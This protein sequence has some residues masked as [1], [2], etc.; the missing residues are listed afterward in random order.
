MKPTNAEVSKIF[1]NVSSRY[2]A[3]TNPYAIRRRMEFFVA[4]AEGKCLE[5]G[6][7][8]GIISQALVKA[9]HDVTATDIAPKMAEIITKKGIKAVVCDAEKLPFPDASF[10][11]VLASEMLYYLDRPQEFLLEAER[12]LK[13]GGVLLISSANAR[14]AWL[15]DWL[16]AVLRPFGVG[17]TY[18]DDPVHTFIPQKDLCRL[19]EQAEFSA[20]AANK[21]LVLPVAF[22]DSFNR[23][24]ECT[25][26]RHAG[27]FI[28]LSARK[29]K[30]PQSL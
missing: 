14:V 6:A 2:D 5:V 21:I 30:F 4:R 3:V 15:Y 12:V 8:T 26:F 9:G 17:G 22:L 24:L 18:F 28:V 1:D 20:L 11:T 19:V 29:Y 16:R 10:D 7:G 27:A 13:P 25:P 23:I